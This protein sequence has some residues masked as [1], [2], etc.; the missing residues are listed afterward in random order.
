MMEDSPKRIIDSYFGK[1]FSERARKLFGRWLRSEDESDEKSELLQQLWNQ[2]AADATD[3]T[4]HD[5]TSPR[6]ICICSGVKRLF[7]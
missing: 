5:W 3:S 2:S 6:D 7:F 4:R 1:H